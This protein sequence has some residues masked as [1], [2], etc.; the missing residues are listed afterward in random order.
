MNAVG[1]GVI[2]TVATQHTTITPIS[3]GQMAR[4]INAT[5]GTEI[6]QI[7]DYTGEFSSYSYAMA[8]GYSNWFNGYD[9]QIYTVGRGPSAMTVSAPDL[10]A[11][12]GQPVVIKGTVYDISAGSKQ[13]SKQQ[14]SP[15]AY[16]VQLTHTMTDWMGYVYQQKPLPTNFTGVNRRQSTSSTQT[17]TTEPSALQQLTQLAH[18][19]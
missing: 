16:H 6:W 2:Y 8:D 5:D 4:A 17:A 11:A 10:A 19:A 7:S 3:K 9:N 12:S 13:T 15:T 1:N 18:T 14:T